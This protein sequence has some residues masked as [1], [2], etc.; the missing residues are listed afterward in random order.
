MDITQL[1]FIEGDTEESE[2][3]ADLVSFNYQRENI[4]VNRACAYKMIYRS[5]NIEVESE[6][7][8]N[9]WI[10]NTE[11]VLTEVENEN[12]AHINIFH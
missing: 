12:Q 9:N 5:I 2:G 3:N 8:N 11:I 1:L 4:Y 10:Q 7:D 6:S